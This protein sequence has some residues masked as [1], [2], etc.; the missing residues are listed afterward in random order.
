MLKHIRI[1]VGNMWEEPSLM[2]KTDFLESSKACGFVKR[3]ILLAKPT[4][5]RAVA[6]ELSQA[7][8]LHADIENWGGGI[9]EDEDEDVGLGGGPQGLIDGIAVPNAFA[10]PFAAPSANNFNER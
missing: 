8:I 3:P 2:M 7:S 4:R 6:P 9:I 5:E 10:E 1:C